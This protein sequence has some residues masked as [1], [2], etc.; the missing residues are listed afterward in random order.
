MQQVHLHQSKPSDINSIGNIKHI[1]NFRTSEYRVFYASSYFN[2]DLFYEIDWHREHIK[3]LDRYSQ[4]PHLFHKEYSTETPHER[5]KSH[6]TE[7]VIEG[8]PFHKKI[9]EEHEKRLKAILSMMPKRIYKKI[10]SISKKYG[11]TPEYFIYDKANRKFFFVVEHLDDAK[12]HWIYL[13][14]EKHQYC[15]VICLK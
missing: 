2:I 6:F 7:H 3:K 11:G 15:D 8:I 5:H 4:K 10:V 14:S 9:L 12:K 1:D 13:V